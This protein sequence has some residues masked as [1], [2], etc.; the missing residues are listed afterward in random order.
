M[1]MFVRITV[2]WDVMPCS[3][4]HGC[5]RLAGT[6]HPHIWNRSVN[7]MTLLYPKHSPHAQ[8]HITVVIHCNVCISNPV[9]SSL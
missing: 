5:L 1:A 4:V 9:Y 2:F 7:S 8:R 6:S 3:L